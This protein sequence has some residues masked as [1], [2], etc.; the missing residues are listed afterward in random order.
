MFELK[1]SQRNKARNEVNIDFSFRVRNRKQ[2]LNV[3]AKPT[4]KK[5]LIYK[6][7]FLFQWPGQKSFLHY[8]SE[9]RI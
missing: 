6:S 3:S 2:T 9:T 8:S 1:K 5:V 4:L 7:M